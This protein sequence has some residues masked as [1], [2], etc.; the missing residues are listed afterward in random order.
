MLDI[1]YKNRSLSFE[2]IKKK[3]MPL[4]LEWYNKI[5]DYVYATGIDKPMTLEEILEKYIEAEIG[6]CEFFAWIINSYE[7]KVG[8][9]KGSIK[10]QENDSIWINSLLI[11]AKYR[12]KGYGREAVTVLFSTLSKSFN[13]QKLYVSV[14]ED[15]KIGITFWNNIGFQTV[16]RLSKHIQL[17]GTLRNTI[18][19]CKVI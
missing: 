16:K 19:M 2:N 8:I 4:L 6:T 15:N 14:I 9:I 1:S 18:I 5:G 3:D 13:L 11:D 12:R 17:A 10:Y 7:E